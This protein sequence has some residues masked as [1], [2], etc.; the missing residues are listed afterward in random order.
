MF[1]LEETQRA[2]KCFQK[3]IMEVG[4]VGFGYRNR[5]EANGNNFTNDEVV[6]HTNSTEESL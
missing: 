6:F 1:T 5:S 4:N 3:Q 2:Q